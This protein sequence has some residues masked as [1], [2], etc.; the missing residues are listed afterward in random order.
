M[1]GKAMKTTKLVT[2][3]LSVVLSLFVLLQS[4]AA[5]LANTLEENGEIGGSAGAIVAICLMAAGIVAIVTRKG[6]KGGSI[7]CAILYGFAALCGLTLAGSYADLT[8]WGGICGILA[9]MHIVFAVKAKPAEVAAEPVAEG[10]K[11]KG[12]KLKIVLI[13][14][15]VIVVL[16][17]A[18]GALGG[19]D[20]SSTGAGS[21][22]A[23][24][25]ANSSADEGDLGDYHVKILD[26]SI[27]KDWDGNDAIRI[28]YEF[29]NND[30]EATSALIGIVT[31]AFQDGVE[32]ES[33]FGDDEDAEYDN[34]SKEIKSGATVTCAEYFT[35]NSES[36][37]EFEVEE[38]FSL[39][40]TKLEKTFSV[41]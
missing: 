18:I 35:L 29:T 28:E 6:G 36:D 1:E 5:G 31:T 10:E 23:E 20:S 40:D 16:F 2:G 32:L 21:G 27:I 11:K 38:T 25:Q 14:V 33:T 26:S 37:V 12:S 13:V 41:K 3:I 4:C 7:A 22:Q 34:W 15:A 19:D 8:I 9:I 39:S 30:E 24:D 17:I